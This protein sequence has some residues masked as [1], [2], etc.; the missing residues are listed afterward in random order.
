MSKEV[1]KEIP[2]FSGYEVSNLGNVRCWRPRPYNAPPPDNPR[3]VKSRIGTNGY[4]YV[5]LGYKGPTP[6]VHRLV[7][8]LFVEG[9]EEGLE[10]AHENG[11]KTDCRASNLRW[12]T[13]KDNFQDKKRHGTWGKKLTQ[14][15]V[16]LIRELYNNGEDVTQA[17]LANKFGVTQG[18]ISK[19]LR[20]VSWEM[21]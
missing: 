15:D 13:R 17:Q 18:Y 6:M 19:V 16:D 4:P 14:D 21:E 11:I 8:E 20:M 1:W 9:Q 7:A 2:D 10:V 5:H 12:T 3:P